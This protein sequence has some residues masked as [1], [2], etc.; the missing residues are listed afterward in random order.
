M[1]ARAGETFDTGRAAADI[2]ALLAEP[3]PA[4][5]PTVAEG[6]PVAGEWTVTRGAGFVIIPLWEGDS[7]TG[8]YAPEWNDVEEAAEGHLADLVQELDRRWGTHRP[9]GM[10]VP[11][12]R[13]A[14]NEPMP[15][16]FQALCDEDLLGDLAVW[17]PVPTDSATDGPWVAVSL[18]QSDGDAPMIMAAVV[19][20]RPIVELE[21]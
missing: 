3:V 9:V 11:V 1:T 7:L 4:T 16:M 5:G 13:S 18:N 14:E 20:D 19:S 8:V 10:R 21:E 15:S 12:F 2:E 6:D 17:G